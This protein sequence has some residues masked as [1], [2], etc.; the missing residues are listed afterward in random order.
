MFDDRDEG[1]LAADDGTIDVGLD[2]MLF[3]IRPVDPDGPG[4][5]APLFDGGEIWDTDFTVPGTSFLFHGGHLW[6]TAYD[7]M[8]SWNTLDENVDG[9]EAVATIPEPAGLTA[10]LAGVAGLAMGRTRKRRQ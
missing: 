5:A 2:H 6:D 9:L 3:S 10:L 4:G 1:G 7:V 8:G